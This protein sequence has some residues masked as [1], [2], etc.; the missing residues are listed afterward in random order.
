MVRNISGCNEGTPLHAPPNYA[1]VAQLAEQLICNQQV[2]GPSP[3]ASSISQTKEGDEH[4]NGYGNGECVIRTIAEVEA[5]IS[6]YRARQLHAEARRD[7]L[8]RREVHKAVEPMRDEFI[9]R[10]NREIGE[11][12]NRI[13]MLECMLI[14]L[15]E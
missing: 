5:E 6:E 3:F 15:G 9:D 2:E 4:M 7:E 12:K 1:G 10:L 14:G 11:W 13:E 8:F